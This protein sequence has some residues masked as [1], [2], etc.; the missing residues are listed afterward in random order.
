MILQVSVNS[1]TAKCTSRNV[2]HVSTL[3][4]Q[5]LYV[6][7]TKKVEIRA[8]LDEQGSSLTRKSLGKLLAASSIVNIPYAFDVDYVLRDTN[9]VLV[10]NLGLALLES[11]RWWI[12]GG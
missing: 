11:I 5:L 3:R 10:E 9:T 2:N 7:R 8:S 1:M 4:Y 12:M 6:T